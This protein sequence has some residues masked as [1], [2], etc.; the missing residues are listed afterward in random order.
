MKEPKVAVIIANYNGKKY[1]K[2]CFKT[3]REQTYKNLKVIIVDNGSEDG[4]KELIKEKFSQF[5]LIELDENTGFAKANNIGMRRAFEKFPDCE[6]IC[7]LNNDIELDK[8]YFYNLVK[9]A[10]KIKSEFKETR[11]KNRKLDLKGKIKKLGILAAKLYFKSKPKHINTAGTLIQR[12]GSGMERGF[13][14]KNSKKYKKKKSV[15]GSCGAAA[16]YT[17]E[18]LEDISFLNQEGEKCY[19]DDDFF[20]YYEDLDLNYRSRLMGY[21]AYFIP[22]P[23][24][25]HYHSATGK[26]FSPFKSF[27]VHRNQFYVLIKNFPL[28]FL[29]LGF[30]MIPVRYFLLLLNAL[31]GKGPSAKLKKNSNSMEIVKIIFKSW[32]DLFKNLPDLLKKRREIQKKRKVSLK[33]FNSWFKKYKASLLKMIFS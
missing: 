27:H 13:L 10:Q 25:Y 12:D 3:L 21:E 24:G 33:E 5:D 32:L 18:M 15:F 16:L 23:F 8:D 7:P 17:K 26:S 20:A 2:S 1:L 11:R 4:S 30:G 9:S 29:L 28:P 19:F 31:F 14:E 22:Q 6:Y